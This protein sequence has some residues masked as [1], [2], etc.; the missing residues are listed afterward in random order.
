MGMFVF[1]MAA[2]NTWPG[3]HC[4]AHITSVRIPQ[5]TCT[6]FCSVLCMQY[7]VQCRLAFEC[8]EELKP[9]KSGAR[10][11]VLHERV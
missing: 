8:A 5:C 2:D 6:S 7:V 1:T 4:M 10:E 3:M 11:N 9:Q